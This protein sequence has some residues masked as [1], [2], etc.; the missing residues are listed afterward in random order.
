MAKI[1]KYVRKL[2][3]DDVSPEDKDAVAHAL[4]RLLR[5]SPTTVKADDEYV[6]QCVWPYCN[7]GHGGSS[8][9]KG[10]VIAEVDWSGGRAWVH[11]YHLEQF[12]VRFAPTAEDLRRQRETDART[13]RRGFRPASEIP[14]ICPWK[15]AQIVIVLVEGRRGQ[16]LSW[17]QSVGE[18][19]ALL[20]LA[21]EDDRVL[22][23]W[24]GEW[25]QDLFELTPEDR[26]AVLDML[27]AG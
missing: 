10:H 9:R 11:A 12:G 1:P 18:K 14:R 16:Q 4:T 19:R 15:S 23:G 8:I 6:G 26:K 5:P 25:R 7:D 13:V 2:V 27:G 22:A 21:G 20:R 24:P 17:A 3:G